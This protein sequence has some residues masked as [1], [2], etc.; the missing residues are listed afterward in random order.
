MPTLREDLHL[1][2]KVP[3]IETDDMRDGLVTT[4]KLSDG[5]VTEGKLA[6]GAVTNEKL[7]EGAVIAGN[8]AEGAVENKNLAEGAVIAGNIAD[9][10]VTEGKLA[11]G[12]VTQGKIADNAVIA[13]NIAENAVT[14]EKI[15]DN[16]V[17]ERNINDEAVTTQK[18]A[19]GAVTEEKLADGSATTAKLA[20]GSVGAGKIANGAVTTQKIATGAV[21][22]G[23]LAPGAVTSD[24]LAPEVITQLETITDA[25]PT[26]GSVKPVQSGGVWKDVAEQM[27][28]QFESRFGEAKNLAE[29]GNAITNKGFSF[30]EIAD[31]VCTIISKADT[32]YRTVYASNLFLKGT[33]IHFTAQ[34]SV[35]RRQYYGASPILPADS[36]LDMQLDHCFSYAAEGAH[37][38]WYIMPY[39]GYFFYSMYNQ[40]WTER[41]FMVLLPEFTLPED[42]EVLKKDVEILEKDVK[43][44]L[45]NV[46]VDCNTPDWLSTSSNNI[47]NRN[48][49]TTIETTDDGAIV[50]VVSPV[51]GGRFSLLMSGLS[52]GRYLLEFD[53]TAVD[54]NGEPIVLSDRQRLFGGNNNTKWG[55]NNTAPFITD[56]FFEETFEDNVG[57]YYYLFDKTEDSPTYFYRSIYVSGRWKGGTEEGTVGDVITITNLRFVKLIDNISEWYQAVNDNLTGLNDSVARLDDSIINAVRQARF[58]KYGDSSSSLGLLHYTDLHGDDIASGQILSFANLLEAF[59]DDIVCTGDVVH[60]YAEGTSSYPQGAEWWQGTGLPEKSLFVLG[61]HDLATPEATPDCPKEGAAAWDGKGKEW[62]Y[63][64]FFAP[65]IS[66]LGVTMPSGNNEPTSPN[67]HSCYWHKDYA[68]KKIRLIGVDCIHRFDGIINPETGEILTQGV[69][70]LTA[71]QEVWLIE[72][73][74]ETLD[75]DSAAYGYS[76]MVLCHYPLDDFSGDNKEWN[77]TEHAFDYNHKADGG[78]VMNGKTNDATSFHWPTS[79]SYEAENRFSM[80]GRGTNDSKNNNNTGE[81]IKAWM[82]NGGKFIAWV[83]GHRHV[84]GLWY[85][86]KFPEIPSITLDQAGWLRGGGT[87][88]RYVS[89]V[90]E[91]YR[92]CANFYS[93]DTE[94]GYIKIVRIGQNMNKL[95]RVV[96]YLCYDYINKKVI[97]ES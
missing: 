94:N 38:V 7:G 56:V 12:A 48:D 67:Y 73:L 84:D 63:E 87:S 22:E 74:N 65:Y 61:N 41:L 71:E 86:T 68:N 51:N 8:I 53:Y 3:L 76:V 42:V 93:I 69:R 34:S 37:D 75:S 49:D 2:H 27:M 31:G 82:Q 79:N 32:A 46:V 78:R 18:I 24:K 85:P 30:G 43:L 39:D 1:G 6:E 20:D 21:V 80:R 55:V 11:D 88:N 9:N 81:I 19:N 62:G 59:I 33:I 15:S 54:E 35:A 10:A 17:T 25:E 23:N 57:H 64:N 47:P 97:S 58:V 45:D 95:M 50:S 66:W 91:R 5:A 83:S 16:A 70:K 36:V 89:L 96:N 40:N 13:G 44:K 90:S 92:L 28:T 14:E 52:K 60:F 77:E 29:V 26:P 4:D 72:K